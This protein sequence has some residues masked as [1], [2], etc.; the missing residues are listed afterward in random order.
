MT[1]IAKI[2]CALIDIKYECEKNWFCEKCPMFV[3][4]LN[5]NRCMIGRLDEILPFCEGNVFKY[6]YRYPK[7]NGV[8]DLKKAREY[9]NQMIDHMEE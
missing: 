3:A 8:Q 2:Q 1:D 4:S 7:K 5:S 9:L 6:L